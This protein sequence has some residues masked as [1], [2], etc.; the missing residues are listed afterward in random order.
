VPTS[1]AL[2]AVSGSSSNI[3]PEQVQQMIIFAL[4]AF[5]LQG[6]KYL[7]TSP[8]LIDSAASNHMTGSPV[9]LQDVR[10]YNGEQYI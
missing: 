3:T 6:K 9:A 2:P 5:G 7:L 1:S 10:K 8:L 4:F